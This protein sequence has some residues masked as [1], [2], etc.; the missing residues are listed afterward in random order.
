METVTQKGVTTI[1]TP[2]S[3][4][5]VEADNDTIHVSAPT[6]DHFNLLVDD[7]AIDSPEEGEDDENVTDGMASVAGEMAQTRRFFGRWPDAGYGLLTPTL[8][9]AIRSIIDHCLSSS[10]VFCFR[11]IIKLRRASSAFT[12]RAFRWVPRA[13]RDSVCY[14]SYTQE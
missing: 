7:E 3:T 8:I 10:S 14:K 5:H 2:K 13:S 9:H 4:V 6:Q 11:H 1:T 12:F